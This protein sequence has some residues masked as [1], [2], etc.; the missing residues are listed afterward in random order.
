MEY[1]AMVWFRKGL[2][3]HDNPALDLAC[4]RSKHLFPVFVLDPRYL[5]P[6]PSAFSPGSTRSGL[7]RIQFLLESLSDLDSSLRKLGSRLL[8]LRGDPVRVVSQILMDV[9]FD[10]VLSFRVFVMT[11]FSIVSLLEI[12]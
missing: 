7:N 10:S 2:R 8:V 6:D 5:D 4:R 12:I 1:N 9:S 11:C 3:I